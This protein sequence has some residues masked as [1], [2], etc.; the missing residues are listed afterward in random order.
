VPLFNFEFDHIIPCSLHFLMAITKLL[1]KKLAMHTTTKSKEG[2]PEMSFAEQIKS[3][4]F[5]APEYIHIIEHHELI[6]QALKNG[7]MRDDKVELIG[8]VSFAIF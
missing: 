2:K 4:K 5:K 7:Y 1:V 3:A 8:Q 6:I